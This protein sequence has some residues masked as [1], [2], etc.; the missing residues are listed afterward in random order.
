MKLY[1]KT[2]DIEF[3][4]IPNFDYRTNY[5]SDNLGLPEKYN[6]FNIAYI[7]ENKSCYTFM[8]FLLGVLYGDI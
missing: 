3:K 6:G 1:K 4:D 2:P 8:V 5:M 7:D